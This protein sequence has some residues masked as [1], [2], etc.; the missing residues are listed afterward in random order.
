METNRSKEDRLEIVLPSLPKDTD[1]RNLW[2]L[3]CEIIQELEKMGVLDQREFEPAHLFVIP[4][5]TFDE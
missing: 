1:L 3:A 5:E 2:V 4:E